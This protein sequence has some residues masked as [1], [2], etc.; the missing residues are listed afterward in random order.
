MTLLTTALGAFLVVAALRDMFD[1]L[2]QPR[3]MGTLCRLVFRGVWRVSRLLVA[4]GRPMEHSGPAAALLTV[5]VW[6]LL[7]VLGWAL[8]YLPHMPEAF[9]FGSSLQPVDSSDVVASL[10]LS[11][12]AVATLGFGDIVP[13]NPA[14]RLA[15]PLQALI[16][17]VLFT[18]AI[19]WIL[20][21]YPALTQR[22]AVARRLTV[23]A[24]TGT[25]DVVATGDVSVASQLL[26]SVTQAV[27]AADM[28]LMQYGETYYFRENESDVSLAARL[29]YVL[30]LIAAGRTATGAEVRHAAEML[31]EATT[32]L[33]SRLDHAYLHTGGT[34]LREILEAYAEDHQ[35]V[36]AGPPTAGPGGSRNR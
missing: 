14:L 9:Y 11:L 35:H 36:V 5:G 28:D 10:Y 23:M 34:D 13:S 30:D 4:R 12:V 25:T 15:I 7:I 2:W 6:A 26:D 21:I 20:Q 32:N 1:T 18:A 27:T 17:F 8:I 24:T 16:G 3:G 29:P 22:R 33:A 31:N 19:S